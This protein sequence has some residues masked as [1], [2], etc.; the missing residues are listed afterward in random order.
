MFEDIRPLL[1]RLTGFRP[2]RYIVV[3]VTGVAFD[4]LVYAVL[5]NLGLGL[6][7]SKAVSI[8]GSVI[9]GYF[10]N[11]KWTF[12]ASPG[13]GNLGR[14]CVVYAV[15]ILVNVSINNLVANLLG[16][17]LPALAAAFFCATLASIVITYNGLKL[18]V[19]K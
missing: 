10:L 17:A 8:T 19:F 13:W 15:S 16:G 14:Y 2:V 11:S 1:T 12:Q 18:W 9:L 4:A 6:S 3:G 7:A 5:L